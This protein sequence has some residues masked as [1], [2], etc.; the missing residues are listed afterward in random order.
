MQSSIRQNTGPARSAL[1]L[2]AF[3]VVCFAAAGL[4]S[5]A[6]ASQ[7]APGGWYDTLDK[8]FFTPPSWLFGPVWTV[9]YLAMAVSGW[10]AWRERGFSGARAAMALFFAQLA[11]NTLWSLVFFGLEA[12][13]LGLVEIVVLWTAILLTIWAFRPISRPAALLLV[14]YLAWVTFATFLNAGIW[15]LNP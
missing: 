4:G 11:L 14:P 6:T 10:L 15:F 7:V 3:V 9:L 13:G 8:P 5:L 12:P 2:L 1:V